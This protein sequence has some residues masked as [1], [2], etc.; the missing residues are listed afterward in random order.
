MQ[1]ML[2]KLLGHLRW[3]DEQTFAALSQQPGA[4][5]DAHERFMHVVAAEHVWLCRIRGEA[6]RVAVWPKFSVDGCRTLMAQNHREF[7]ALVAVDEAALRRQVAYTTSDGR[8]FTDTVA[9]ILMHVAMHGSWHRG[10]IAL[11]MRQS[12][13][14][15]VPSDYILYVRG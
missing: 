2:Q 10:Q 8:P 13:G 14:T 4:A 11:R 9:D 15:P 6:P 1:G 12:G 5:T 7:A 3:A